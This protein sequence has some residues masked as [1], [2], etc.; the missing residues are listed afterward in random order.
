M[1]DAAHASAASGIT[2]REAL[3]QLGGGLGLAGVLAGIG[4]V[5]G[6]EPETTPTA[7]Q[8][9]YVFNRDPLE[10]EA[11]AMLPAGSVAPRGWL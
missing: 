4:P 7:S 11:F 8:S 9:P 3:Q 6:V 2:R 10:T 1:T 5:T